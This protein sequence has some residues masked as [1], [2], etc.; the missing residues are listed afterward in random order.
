MRSTKYIRYGE[1]RCGEVRNR[2]W[3]SA[4]R[5]DVG[6]YDMDMGVGSIIL[7]YGL[8]WLSFIN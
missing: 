5:C 4:L 3:G 6:K 7:S 1:V 8:W 2:E